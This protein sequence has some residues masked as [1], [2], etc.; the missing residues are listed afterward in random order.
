[1]QSREIND[2]YNNQTQESIYFRHFYGYS[3]F[4]FGSLCRSLSTKDIEMNPE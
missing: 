4:R 2:N 1:M 3:L